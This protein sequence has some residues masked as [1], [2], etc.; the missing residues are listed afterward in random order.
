MVVYSKV[1]SYYLPLKPI[2]IQFVGAFHQ[3]N[4]IAKISIQIDSTVGSHNSHVE[5][6]VTK[7]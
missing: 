1:P 4:T 6:N 5:K 2:N 7:L 3:K